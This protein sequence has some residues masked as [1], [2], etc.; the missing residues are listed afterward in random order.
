[1]GIKGL[2]SFLEKSNLH[3]K[4]V[5][6][7]N[8]ND[9]QR[10]LIICD[11]SSYLDR[12]YQSYRREV[13][14]LFDFYPLFVECKRMKREFER[15]GFELIIF[16]DGYY[17]D[18]KKNA[19]AQRS[20]KKFK[21]KQQKLKIIRQM[22]QT[23]DKA[24]RKK[25][26]RKFRFVV[27]SG[28]SEYCVQALA[29]AG[30]TVHR[31]SG[32]VDIDQDMAQFMFINQAKTYGVMSNDSDFFGFNL[33]QHIKWINKWKF[34]PAKGSLTFSYYRP[35]DVWKTL[36]LS[37]IEHRFYLITIMGNDFVKT[38]QN[39]FDRLKKKSDRNK[40]KIEII[41]NAIKSNV[42]NRPNT[43]SMNIVR[44][45]YVVKDYENIEWMKFSALNVNTRYLDL[46][47]YKVFCSGTFFHD[48]NLLGSTI[49]QKLRSLRFA[50]YKKLDLL[51]QKVDEYIPMM[52]DDEK[53]N[54]I[55]AYHHTCIELKYDND[56]DIDLLKK[57][58]RYGTANLR[59]VF[60]CTL[61]YLKKNKIVNDDQFIAL[62]LQYYVKKVR[63]NKW[64]K[65][66]GFE[67]FKKDGIPM[68]Y[69]LS[70]M[71]LY[72]ECTRLFCMNKENIVP[73]V[74]K[75]F[76]GPLYHYFLFQ[77]RTGDEC[78][79]VQDLLNELNQQLPSRS[80]RTMRSKQKICSL[81]IYD[82]EE[83]TLWITVVCEGKKKVFVINKSIWMKKNVFQNITELKKLM[84]DKFRLKGKNL[85]NKALFVEN[86]EI[87]DSK[88]WIYVVQKAV[89][90]ARKEVVVNI[91][92]KR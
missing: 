45:F 3:K 76:D 47:R 1:M 68:V 39:I 18:N 42:L 46:K 37:D 31:G 6:Y 25:L 27:S 66:K 69:D 92:N 73:F 41:A 80:I 59:K 2:H 14:L 35:C 89:D 30:F 84:F 44:N 7:K 71:W 65:L 87:I 11:S 36:N 24:K 62:E 13:S 74:Y 28:Y 51:L 10:K 63:G 60:N 4:D 16:H 85:L 79:V 8:G 88:Q 29:A 43:K 12:L 21:E 57:D 70:A 64:F 40:T 19:Y 81:S 58:G 67:Q 55:D 72:L 56:E 54:K 17:I 26:E 49:H 90:A 33:P 9:K 5:I 48:V 77:Q 15:F 86:D 38:K 34:A 78:G 53:E 20:K 32:K 50:M 82:K 61:D 91:Q 75:L 23:S 22:H 83:W 52:I